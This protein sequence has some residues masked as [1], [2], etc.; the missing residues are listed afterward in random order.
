M[1]RVF[2][3]TYPKMRVLDG[4]RQPVV[5]NGKRVYGRTKKWY[6]E[7]TDAQVVV[8]RVPGYTDKKATEQ[9]A[10][11]LERQVERE[12]AGILET[13]HEHLKSPIRQ[14]IDDWLADLSRA[15]RSPEYVR[16]LKSRIDKMRSESG[17]ISLA[18]IRP[19]SA[20]RWLAT[21]RCNGAAERTV[22]HYLATLNA[23]CNW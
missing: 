11:T 7:Y 17:W 10:T 16:K 4:E 3:P 12:K 13:A 19:D 15:G 14:H 18:S 22:N 6:I 9:L 5:R 23:F 2:K 21:Q 20:S 1:P 8:R